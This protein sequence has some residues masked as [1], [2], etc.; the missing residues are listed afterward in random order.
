LEGN[1][2][3]RKDEEKFYEKSREKGFKLMTFDLFFYHVFL[4]R[5]VY[6][7]L[8]KKLL[9]YWIFYDFYPEKSFRKILAKFKSFGTVLAKL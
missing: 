1:P 9:K 2:W 5:N 4:K 6:Q 7:S 3:S 8:K